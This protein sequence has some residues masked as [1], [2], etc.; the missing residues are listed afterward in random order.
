[1]VAPVHQ[2]L[3]TLHLLAPRR[4]RRGAKLPTWQ[5]ITSALFMA[6]AIWALIRIAGRLYSGALFRFGRRIPL[7]DLWQSTKA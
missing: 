1:M 3:I 4:R 2:T 7:R 5:L 6:V